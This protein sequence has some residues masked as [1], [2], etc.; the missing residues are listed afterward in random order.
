MY[1]PM[2]KWA[3]SW[4]IFRILMNENLRICF[5]V[6]K[7]SYKGLPFMDPR[8]SHRKF[9]SAEL[10]IKLDLAKFRKSNSDV[11]KAFLFLSFL[12]I[13]VTC[14]KINVLLTGKTFY[15]FIY[16]FWLERK[17]VNP[18]LKCFWTYVCYWLFAISPRKKML[19]KVYR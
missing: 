13:P 12:F 4:T 14:K 15:L 19:L 17:N 5:L 8:L 7:C 10:R 18:G 9:C 3:T 6:K 16:S 11:K 1:Y 2:W